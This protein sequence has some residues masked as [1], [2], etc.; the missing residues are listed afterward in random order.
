MLGTD[1]MHSDML[2]STKAAF[3]SGQRHDNI[4]YLSAYQRF[5]NIHNYLAENNYTGDS[6]NNL[7]VL[8][9]FV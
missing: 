2:Q 7:V 4:N 1:G 5:R 6:D 3:F 8:D 9:Y